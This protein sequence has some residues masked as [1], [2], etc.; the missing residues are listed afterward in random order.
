MRGYNLS[1]NKSENYS[2][3]RTAASTNANFF[4]ARVVEVILDGDDSEIGAVYYRPFSKILPEEDQR[5]YVAYP[6]NKNVTIFPLKNEIVLIQIAPSITLGQDT[7][8][9]RAY[10]TTVLNIWDT[11][12]YNGYPD[13]SQ[14]PGNADTGPYFRERDDVNPLQPFPGDLLIQ[15]RQGQSIRMTG[16]TYPDNPWTINSSNGKPLLI[17]SN[18]QTE[19]ETGYEHIVEDIN[20]DASSIY[21]TSDHFINLTPASIDRLS[22]PENRPPVDAASYK[23]AQ[24]ILNSGRIYLNARDES[25]FI[26][27]KVSIGLNATSVNIEGSKYVTLDGDRIYIGAKSMNDVQLN[28]EPAL[29]GNQVESF[30]SDLLDMLQ[31][32]AVALGASTE[33][34]LIERGK[35]ML[36][37]IKMLRGRINPSG[38]PSQLKST[39]VYI[40]PGKK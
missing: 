31:G 27:S 36:P 13:Q 4:P 37:V 32:T 40:D 17:L 14:S 19:A 16:V 20:K 6:L 25:A 22:Y 35:S 3:G 23:G 39:K 24:L 5:S 33:P 30:L 28:K 21:F 10:Y 1:L 7:S 18:G 38:R 8:S 34:V 2:T 11:P 9:T 29:L 15:G 26:S 12:H